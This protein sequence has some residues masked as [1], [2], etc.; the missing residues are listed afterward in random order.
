MEPHERLAEAMSNRRLE[1]RMTWKQVAA[2]AGISVEALGAIRRGTYKPT[3][4]TARGL[5]DALQWGHG[6]VLGFYPEEQR[7]G[8][9]RP[10]QPARPEAD[11]DG[12]IDLDTFVPESPAEKALMAI[13]RA[14]QQE[15]ENR[16]AIRER[17]DELTR[18]LDEQ[19]KKIEELRS[20]RAKNGSDE[21]RRSA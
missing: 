11:E 7:R 21:P 6:T 19:D 8:A 4:L 5:D 2:V 14:S 9:R 15:E 1:L 16:Q 18:K 17:L 20:E 10:Q 12:E 3:D 13:Y